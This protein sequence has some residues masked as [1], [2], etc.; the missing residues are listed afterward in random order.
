MRTA[1]NDVKR[2]TDEQRLVRWQPNVRAC[3]ATAT[4]QLAADCFT[5]GYLQKTAMA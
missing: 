5:V 4:E 2:R 3:A 1:R